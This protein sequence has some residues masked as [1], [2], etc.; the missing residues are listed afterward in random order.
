MENIHK[1]IFTTII[2]LLLTS[3]V[4]SAPKAFDS[5][6]NELESLQKDC[7]QYLKDP[8]ISKKLQTAC[9]KFNAKVNKAF[10]VG[11]PLDASVESNTANEKKVAR[12][13]A[14]LRKA[15][16]SGDSLRKLK[17][18]REKKKAEEEKAKR[19]VLLD[20]QIDEYRKACDGRD[21]KGCFK[22][23]VMYADGRGVKQDDKKAV[24]LWKKAADQGHARAQD[25]LGN[26]YV[27]AR[28][29]KQDYKKAAELW[30]KAADQGIANAQYTLGV[31][32]A[33]GEGVK[34]NDKKAVEFYTKAAN[35]GIAKAQYKLGLMYKNGR[36]V[37]Q[38]YKKAVEL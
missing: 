3:T 10:K 19:K 18:S 16:E 27:F 28:G 33:Y 20:K 24:E 22:L 8:K 38:D 4:Q 14:L 37:K 30:K 26:R 5:L 9:K 34:Q 12:Y 13:L 1:Y 32:Y 23:G 25:T 2:L 7:K 17:R 35:Q 11:Y 21:A 15:D 31:M 29:V 6:G 36:G